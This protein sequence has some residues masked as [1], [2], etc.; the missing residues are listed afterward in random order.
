MGGSPS[1]CLNES[2]DKRDKLPAK[3]KLRRE[4]SFARPHNSKETGNHGSF[5]L[6]RVLKAIEDTAPGEKSVF[7]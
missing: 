5:L 7:T 2:R 6:D 4:R 1:F 3:F